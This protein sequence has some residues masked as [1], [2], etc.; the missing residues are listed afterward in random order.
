MPTATMTTKGQIT[1]PQPVR[2]ALGLHAGSKVDFVPAGDGYK[3]VPLH[4]GAPGRLR[5]R[6]SGRVSQPASIEKMDAAISEA[7]SE[8]HLCAV[9]SGAAQAQRKALKASESRSTRSA[10]P[11]P[12]TPLA[13]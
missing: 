5:G 12:P 4:E 10:P 11:T 7:A 9:Q 13:R 2:N 3:V 6:F 1:I 8:C